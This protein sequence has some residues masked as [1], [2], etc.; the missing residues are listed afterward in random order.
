M[1][2]L[3]SCNQPNDS[4]TANVII[5]GLQMR[6]IRLIL[7]KE[8]AS[9]QSVDLNPGLCDFEACATL[10]C[11]TLN[12]VLRFLETVSVL[13]DHISQR[14]E[15]HPHERRGYGLVQQAKSLQARPTRVRVSEPSFSGSELPG[16]TE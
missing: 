5:P 16:Y 14:L 3:G 12:T 13:E 2:T 7:P 6:H 4:A 11:A 9:K 8:K 15:R 10:C 1:H